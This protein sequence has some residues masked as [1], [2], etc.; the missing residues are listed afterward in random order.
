MSDP[1]EDGDAGEDGD[2]DL[3]EEAEEDP[4]NAAPEDLFDDDDDEGDKSEPFESHFANPDEKSVPEKVK[5][6][7]HGQWQMQR[8]ATKTARI[9]ISS[10]KTEEGSGD[11]GAWTC[12][13]AV[14]PETEEEA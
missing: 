5:V 8:V 9:L 3:V 2:I 1:S 10:P 14:Q 7:E 4:E 12:I 11:G 13:G 6:V